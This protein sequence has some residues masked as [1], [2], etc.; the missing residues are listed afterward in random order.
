M[1]VTKTRCVCTENIAC[2]YA[3]ADFFNIDFRVFIAEEVFLSQNKS[4][5]ALK[6]P[7]FVLQ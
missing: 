7:V 4:L 3:V 6:T 5:F 2:F 1:F